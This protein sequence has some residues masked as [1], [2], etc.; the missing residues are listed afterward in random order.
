MRDL[1]FDLPIDPANWIGTDEQQAIAEERAK[2]AHYLAE[3]MAEE[4]AEENAMNR[5]RF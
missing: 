2:R 1:P 5:H 4:L 3:A